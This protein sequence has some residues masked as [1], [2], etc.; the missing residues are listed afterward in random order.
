MDT[1]LFTFHEVK[2]SRY[3]NYELTF[4]P[5]GVAVG[6][7]RP[8]DD[9]LYMQSFLSGLLHALVESSHLGNGVT[10]KDPS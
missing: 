8:K 7:G 2:T 5:H 6:S 10:L 9:G 1:Q 3:E 4:S